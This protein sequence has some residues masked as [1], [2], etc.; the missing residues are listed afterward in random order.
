MKFCKN[1]ALGKTPPWSYAKQFLS[2][3]RLSTEG[4]SM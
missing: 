4:L 3:N 1:R 2:W